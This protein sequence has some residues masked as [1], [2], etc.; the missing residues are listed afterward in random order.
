MKRKPH[1]TKVKR[2]KKRILYKFMPATS[3][4]NARSRDNMT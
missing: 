2:G 1:S 3:L 4:S